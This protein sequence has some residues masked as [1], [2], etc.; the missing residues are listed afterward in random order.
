MWLDRTMENS[1]SVF[2]SLN[3]WLFIKTIHGFL[4][5]CWLCSFSYSWMFFGCSFVFFSLGP[6]VDISYIRSFARYCCLPDTSCSL[7]SSSIQVIT[8]LTCYLSCVC[9]CFLLSVK[10]LKFNRRRPL[11]DA[12]DS[13][14]QNT[15]FVNGMSNSVSVTGYRSVFKFIY[16]LFF[17]WF[18]FICRNQIVQNGI[19]AYWQLH[20]RRSKGKKRE[21]LFIPMAKY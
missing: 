14:F 15:Y 12:E 11:P 19:S 17:V 13:E 2:C 16:L 18:V 3:L 8:V 21:R 9:V 6:A 4:V 20:G 5:V 7:N 1:F 10:V